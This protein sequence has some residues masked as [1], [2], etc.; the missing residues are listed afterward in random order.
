MMRT[1][2]EVPSQIN[3]FGATNFSGILLP[4]TQHI[5]FVFVEIPTLKRDPKLSAC[6]LLNRHLRMSRRKCEM[7]LGEINLT[8][9]AYKRGSGPKVRFI[10]ISLSS[11]LQRLA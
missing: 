1:G 2:T 8:E 9:R 3:S 10:S 6:S 7:T 11:L 5:T 4:K